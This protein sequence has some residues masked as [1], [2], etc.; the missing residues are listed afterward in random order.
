MN[1][2]ITRRAVLTGLLGA[3]LGAGCRQQSGSSAPVQSVETFVKDW[4]RAPSGERLPAIFVGHGTPMSAIRPNQWTE[5]WLEVGSK[6][7]RPDAILMISAHWLTQ[8][9]ALVTASPKPPM[10]YDLQNFPPEMYQIQYPAPGEVGLAREVAKTLS[11]E[12]P[13]YGDER[14][15][16]D[17]A[18]WVVLKYMFPKADVPVIQLSIDYS[19][20]PAFH[21]DLAKHLQTLRNKGVMIMGSG[22]LVH[23]LGKREPDNKP[24]DWALEFDETIS[25]C[26]LSGNHKGAVDFLH[27]GSMA[28]LSQPTHDHFLPLLYCLGVT[29]PQDT[30][31]TFNDSFQWSAVT[32]RSFMMV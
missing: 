1:D 30:I 14:W 27:L 12:L 9:G 26:V 20:P 16:Y 31:T 28:A 3:A 10:N 15:G 19:K 7:P 6:L 29:E 4:S 5:T 17:H 24:Y 22:N 21:Y 2:S 13:V 11:S 25:Q 23:N 18:T 32:M 8:G